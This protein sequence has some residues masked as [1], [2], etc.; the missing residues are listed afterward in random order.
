[1]LSCFKD[2]SF[3]KYVPY[4]KSRIVVHS[5]LVYQHIVLNVSLKND[6]EKIRQRSPQVKSLV[7]MPANIDISCHITVTLAIILGKL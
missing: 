5:G 4:M 3:F 6:L 7:V 1:M 2:S